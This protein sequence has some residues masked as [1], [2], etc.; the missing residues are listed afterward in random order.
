MRVTFWLQYFSNAMFGTL[1]LYNLRLRC[2]A[3]PNTYKN[4]FWFFSE[5]WSSS[6]RIVC[7]C[8]DGFRPNLPKNIGRFHRKENTNFPKRRLVRSKNVSLS[9]ALLF[10]VAV[11]TKI[12]LRPSWGLSTWNNTCFLFKCRVT[13]WL[14]LFS[15]ATFGT[16]ALYILRLR[17]LAIPNTYKNS[18]WFFS[19]T[20]SSSFRIV[21]NCFDGFRPNLPKNIGRSHRKKNTNF[22][23]WRWVPSKNVCLRSALLFSLVATKKYVLRT[24]WGLST[25]NNTCFLFKCRVTFWLRYFSPNATF[26]TLA[27]YILR[28]RCFAIPNT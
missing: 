27:L 9:S 14:R 20:W 15:D 3:I 21:C 13:F 24:S 22:V 4:S 26:D 5:T 16:L 25:W 7:N 6:F 28:L 17:C 2:L 10:S 18:F 8:F 11:T 19:E 23:K 1:A 12:V